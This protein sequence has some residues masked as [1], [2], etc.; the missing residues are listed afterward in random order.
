[1]KERLEL[2]LF[3]TASALHSSA[4]CICGTLLI[5]FSLTAYAAPL[6]K[7]CELEVVDKI[8]LTGI[9]PV[10]SNGLAQ[11]VKK[12]ESTES[13]ETV[14]KAYVEKWK[15]S[16]SEPFDARVNDGG[17]W[18]I[19]SKVIGNC[20]HTAQFEKKSYNASGYLSALNIDIDKNA[21]LVNTGKQVPQL[22]G[23]RVVSDLTHADPGK[24]ARTTMITNKFSPDANA[25]F[26][27]RTIGEDGW[28]VMSDHRV[29]MKNRATAS[30]ALT[31][32]K[33]H[34]SQIIVITEGSQGS[35]VL[36]QWMEKP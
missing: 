31:F 21:A 17:R 16:E 1:M 11:V 5:V 29:P 2:S 15:H 22:Y 25:D 23:S 8:T 20:F 27:L 4:T 30:R 26:Y 12:I 9:G 34:E 24:K 14:A 18:L 7:K 19:V 36:V 32:N 3:N 35:N 6:G 28:K 33:G 10:S 13:K